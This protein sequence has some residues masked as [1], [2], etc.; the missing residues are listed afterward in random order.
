L[1]ARRLRAI[2]GSR[3][4]EAEMI[5]I[6]RRFVLG[7]VATALAMPLARPA[8]A[9][10]STPEPVNASQGLAIQGYDVVAYFTDGRPVR[11]VAD[12]VHRWR[13]AEWRFASAAHRDAFAAA[14]ERYAP[15]YGGFC[16][17]GVARGTRVDVDPTAWRIV[18]GKLYL[19]Y[20]QS[21]NRTWLNDV[22]GYIRQADRNWVQ[23]RAQ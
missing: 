3:K 19:N 13:D 15:Q 2:P 17:Y 20:S 23:L 18:D 5:T 1:N 14:P 11:G 16:A 21:V 4:T 10:Q 12:F 6:A 9:Q 8:A 22:P 7:A